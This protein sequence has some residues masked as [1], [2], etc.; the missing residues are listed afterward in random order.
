MKRQRKSQKNSVG[1]VIRY[2]V[3]FMLICGGSVLIAGGC[4]AYNIPV[5]LLG[6]LMLLIGSSLSARWEDELLRS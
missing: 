5:A 4:Q 1:G 2:T 6:I 3:L